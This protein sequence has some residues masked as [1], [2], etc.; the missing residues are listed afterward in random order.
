MNLD[1]SFKNILDNI[2]NEKIDE[3]IKEMKEPYN[4]NIITNFEV[5]KNSLL[6]IEYEMSK[7]S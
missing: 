6:E 2:F 1:D 4:K 7:L 3:I 5:I